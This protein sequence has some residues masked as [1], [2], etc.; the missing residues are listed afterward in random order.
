MKAEGRIVAPRS[1]ETH[2]GGFHSV[3]LYFY[4]RGIPS[5]YNYRWAMRNKGCEHGPDRCFRGLYVNRM[6]CRIK[7]HQ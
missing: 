6:V 4:D 1:A 5:S 2:G 3:Y 7:G